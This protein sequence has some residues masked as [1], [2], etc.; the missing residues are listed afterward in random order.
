MH[1]SQLPEQTGPGSRPTHTRLSPVP[2]PLPPR[3][4]EGLFDSSVHLETSH[5][6]FA[7]KQEPTVAKKTNPEDGSANPRPTLVIQPFP[8][9]KG[10]K[11]ARGPIVGKREQLCFLGNH[12]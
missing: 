5:T 1:I 4:A 8:A 11:L 3:S 7:A 2:E 12:D 6:H 10:K 9:R